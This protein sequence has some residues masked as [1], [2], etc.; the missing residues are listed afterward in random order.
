MRLD[1]GEFGVFSRSPSQASARTR[2]EDWPR[3]NPVVKIRQSR[4]I[5]IRTG[6]YLG[7]V[8]SVGRGRGHRS[9]GPVHP[10]LDPSIASAAVTRLTSKFAK[11]ERKRQDNSI[12]R[13]AKRGLMTEVAR[14]RGPIRTHPSGLMKAARRPPHETLD[15]QARSADL[16]VIRQST[17]GMS[18]ESH[19]KGQVQSTK[20]F[21]PMRL[22]SYIAVD[23][24]AIAGELEKYF[25]SGSG[26]AIAMK[27][28]LE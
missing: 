4:Q 3:R 15:R 19:Q 12:R 10:C 24:E 22:K 27:R 14:I 6:V 23:T 25:K 26:K 11:T 13:A 28:F 20:A 5:L 16:T 17:W 8:G 2:A 18:V 9:D 7:N 1:E 21:T